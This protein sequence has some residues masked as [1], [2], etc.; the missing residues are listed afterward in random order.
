MRD[1]GWLNPFKSLSPEHRREVARHRRLA[2]DAQERLERLTTAYRTLLIDPRYEALKA[3]LEASLG[4]QLT[5]LLEVARSCPKCAPTAVR[6]DALHDVVA[7]PLH[8]AFLD[9]QRSR[10][11]GVEEPVLE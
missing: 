11:E 10:Y 7:R 8:Q 6:V 9:A 2:R 1:N 3:D 5:Q 4:E